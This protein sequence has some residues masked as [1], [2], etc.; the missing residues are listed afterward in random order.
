MLTPCKFN[1]AVHGHKGPPTENSL[2]EWDIKHFWG[3]SNGNWC[4]KVQKAPQCQAVMLIQSGH[5][6]GSEMCSVESSHFLRAVD[7]F[8][9]PSHK[10]APFT[11]EKKYRKEI[12][13]TPHCNSS[14]QWIW[15]DIRWHSCKIL[16]YWFCSKGWVKLLLLL[17][18]N[19]FSLQM[20]SCI[21]LL[22]H[23]VLNH[24]S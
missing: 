16:E 9:L 18:E 19:Q 14:W 13:S 1:G 23:L 10:I 22:W 3:S 7:F 21:F 8:P 4:L 17:H 15:K 2:Q 24:S 11:K 12:I 5:S 6:G 20:S